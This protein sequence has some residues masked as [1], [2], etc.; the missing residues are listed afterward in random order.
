MERVWFDNVIPLLNEYLYGEWDKLQA[1]LGDFISIKDVPPVLK[2]IYD[3]NK[4]YDFKKPYEVEFIQSIWK[5][6]LKKKML[7]S[8]SCF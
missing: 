2:E 6:S 3:D 1:I 4:Y 7:K 5:A 8:L